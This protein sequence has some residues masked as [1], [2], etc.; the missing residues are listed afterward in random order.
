MSLPL[1]LHLFALPCVFPSFLLP[2][3][4]VYM[5]Q[6]LLP[7][8]PGGNGQATENIYLEVKVKTNANEAQL[9]VKIQET[10]SKINTQLRGYFFN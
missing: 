2:V 1:F 6:D 9:K 3:P 5:S 4:L 10:V 8:Q 7:W